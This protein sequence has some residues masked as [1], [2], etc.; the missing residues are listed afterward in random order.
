MVM[1]YTSFAA[2]KVEKGG[3][4]AK[5]REHLAF[6]MV[7]VNGLIL[8]LI[9]FFVASVFVERMIL[10]EKE[11][12]Q[13]S[14]ERIVSTD[15]SKVDNDLGFLNSMVS[16]IEEGVALNNHIRKLTNYSP[17]YRAM[18]GGYIKDVYYVGADMNPAKSVSIF[19][20]MSGVS[21][22][23]PLQDILAHLKSSGI[24]YSNGTNFTFIDDK[25]INRPYRLSDRPDIMARDLMLIRKVT[26]PSNSNDTGYLL[27]IVDNGGE[28]IY[29]GL[30]KLGGISL[31]VVTT[32][33]SQ[34]PLY[35]WSKRD[36]EFYKSSMLFTSERMIG[37]TKVVVRGTIDPTAQMALLSTVP[38]LLLLFLGTLTIFIMIFVWKSQSSSRILEK[39]YVELEHKNSELGVEVNERE[40][41]NH[42]LRKSE[43]ENKAII[44]A[45][46]DVI[47]EISLSGDILFLNDAWQ[48]L[49][50]NAVDDSIGQNLFEM[51]N[52]K[53]QD[54]QRKAVSQLIKGL[55]PGYRVM[56]SI[57]TAEGK[58]RA[59]EMTV[60]MVRMDE[61]RAM[62]VVGSFTDIEERQRA[63][64][65]LSEAER[66]YRSIWENSA[67]GIAQISIDGQIMSANPA[68][69]K[70]F[71]FDTPEIMMHEVQN[72]HKQLFENAQDRMKILNIIREEKIQEE[73]E[74]L[75]VRRDG[76]KFWIK[77]ST[78]PVYDEHEALVYYELGIEDV[79]KRKDA[80]MRLQEA[81]R[82][83]DIANRAKS[84]FLA[85][86]SHE[87]R[88][89]LNSI[90]GFSEI[91]RNEVFGPVEPRSYWEYAR[92]IH[93]SGKHLLSIINQILDISK[94][95]A[96]D[97]ELR[98]TRV[99][100]KKVLKST[101]DLMSPKIK[102]AGLLMPEPDFS[103]L[104]SIIGE[105]SA[106][107]QMLNNILSNSIKFTPSGGQISLSA[108]VDEQGDMRISV[109][110]T[111]IGLDQT[112]IERVTS[113]FGSLDGR[114]SKSSYGLGL[115][116]SLV[117]SLMRL[118]GGRVEIISSK[119][120]GTTVTMIFPK[121]RIDKAR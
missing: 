17:L 97:R 27:V 68:F 51:I 120:I 89:P 117:S 47:F 44:N 114:L 13:S 87:L 12:V 19:H 38:W 30:Q 76:S 81:K 69:A 59:I 4:F 53:D 60:S 104:P 112:E 54:E 10:E 40:R 2:K 11:R 72:A 83:S 101:L 118:H 108:E 90:I 1:P 88:T 62:R 39:M 28:G 34:D 107:R 78:R 113:R 73:H 67:N 32:E 56:T 121:E 5:V 29:S 45:I 63:Q 22:N 21:S 43:R 61:N 119:G 24:D 15:F 64:W 116:L 106:I 115:G 111:G 46:S 50:G 42:V 20:K 98:E 41:L 105:E 92:D 48:K 74:F 31:F 71:G 18:Q 82:E 91:I 66:K 52:P 102:E 110:D 93:E 94:I 6:F 35:R 58:L 37:D 99:D 80:E 26:N 95:D 96:G 8:T 84:E 7:A 65:A 33:G 55:R 100:M 103:H 36:D 9:S 86:M 23:T 70:L 77:E 79:S 16:N 75:A 49:T 57:R 14:V 3:T 25:A 85:N 109:T